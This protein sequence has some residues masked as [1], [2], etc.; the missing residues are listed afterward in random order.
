MSSEQ[1]NPVVVAYVASRF[2]EV[3]QTWMLRELNAVASDPRVECELLSLFPPMKRTGTA[4]PSA[5]LWM[6]RL[7]RPRP[8]SAI[9]ALA[10][11]LRRSPVRLLGTIAVIVGGYGRRPALLARALATAKTSPS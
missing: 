6:P 3:T 8:G 10:W 9:L 11:W 5:E 2:P 1:R 7:R 4:H